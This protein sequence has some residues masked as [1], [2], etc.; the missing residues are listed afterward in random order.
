[1]RTPQN[2]DFPRRRCA[3][4][5]WGVVAATFHV[6][7]GVGVRSDDA[8]LAVR[9]RRER[10]VLATL[11][12]AR[13]AVVSVDRLAHDVWQA[14][15]PPNAPASLQVAVS[16]LRAVL[17]PDRAHGAPYRLLVTTPAGYALHTAPGTVD[18]EEFTALVEEAHAAIDRGDETGAESTLTRARAL[19][20][21]EPYAG[22]PDTDLVLAERARLQEVRQ[23]AFELRAE[24]LLAQGRQAL[25]AA[26]L[27][28][29]LATYPFRERLWE[30]TALALYRGGRQADALTTLR[31]ARSTLA[32]ELGLDPSPE[33]QRLEARILDQDPALEAP[34]AHRPPGPTAPPAPPKRVLVGRDA[35]FGALRAQLH[36][37]LAGTTAFALVEGEPG[38]G[39]TTLLEELAAHATA[40]GALVLWGRSA[41][42]GLAP[43]FWPW[44]EALRALA[45][46][47]YADRM[48]EDAQ[49]LTRPEGLATGGLAQDRS[50]RLYEAVVATLQ[51]VAAEQPL[52]VILEDLHWADSQSAELLTH[53][54]VRLHDCRVLLVAS[55][56][57]LELGRADA[58]A[59]AVAGVARRPGARRLVL[60]AIR[61]AAS[62]ALVEQ[63]VDR[64]V[65]AAVAAAIHR[66][67]EGNPFYITELSR[68]LAASGDLG[69]ATAVEVAQV[70]ASVRDVVR[71]RLAALPASTRALLEMAAVLGRE[72][73]LPILLAASGLQ[74]DDCLDALEDA[75]VHRVLAPVPDVP[76]RYRF[77]H[78]LVAEAALADLSSLRVARLHARAA[79]DL[80]AAGAGWEEIAAHLW[81]AG[82]TVPAART[83]AALERA[84]DLALRRTAYESAEDLLDR[85][86]PLR[87]QTALAEG[88]PDAEDAE[89]STMIALG[90]IRRA[91]RGYGPAYESLPTERAHELAART[92]R[93]DLRVALLHLQWGACATQC[94]VPEATRIAERLRDLGRDSGDE[95]LQLVSHLAWG[96]QCWHLGRLQEAA[97]HMVHVHAAMEQAD[98]DLIRRIERF[99]SAALFAGFAVHVLDLAGR[100]DDGAERFLRVGARYS[101]PYELVTVTN[102][103]GYSAVCA[104]DPARMIEWNRRLAPPA[105]TEFGMF[106]A[107]ALMFTGWATALLEDPR[108]GM[109]MIERG[110][111]RFLTMGARTGLSAMVEAQV[112]AMLAAGQPVQAAAAVLARGR[113]EA[114]AAGEPLALPY[115]DLAEARVAAASGASGGDVAE[116]L[117]RALAGAE[118]TGN[119]LLGPLVLRVA[120]EHGVDLGQ[121]GT[122][123]LSIGGAGVGDG[124]R[125]ARR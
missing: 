48:P 44:L 84:A 30:L 47:G 42:A 37:A 114:E 8:E 38:I 36:E 121:S 87:R 69:D 9:G 18:A 112:E 110:M 72:V 16:R 104:G 91:L 53:L 99:E 66:R 86:L 21:G 58:A 33:L 54:A 41:D 120:A 56:R 4:T 22:A 97:D 40:A 28:P 31:R 75:L 85:A 78:A 117:R 82:L 26:E 19:W 124:D 108:A 92:P 5:L 90:A 102:F 95:V 111:D 125:S 34:R 64:P 6:L 71:R 123:L 119:R 63:A 50:F 68:L 67:S 115:L 29:L 46:H 76:G 20:L 13:G 122:A 77:A 100:I 11:L 62:G 106:A 3:S 109:V 1:M 10:A 49:A 116:A 59:D 113:A 32:A 24:A 27:E 118:R 25:V 14:A 83:A 73:D 43:A 23:L 93:L 96:V 2:H 94:H 79:D 101:L 65:P 52:V 12:A 81:A 89:L 80:E 17:E 107:T 74:E 98:P 57:E 60:R 39:K 88:T 35:E 103:A 70:P 61:E 105:D 55:L 45:A 15:P 7:G 51:T